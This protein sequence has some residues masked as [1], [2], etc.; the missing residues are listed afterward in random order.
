MTERKRATGSDLAKVDAH[1]IMPE[2][3]AEIPE[4]TDDWFA[5]AE[6]S[7]GGRPVS[8]DAWRQAARGTGRPESANPK[9]SGQSKCSD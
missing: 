5:Q 8:D 9:D 1:K 2:E 6:P 7:I 3:Y 4:L